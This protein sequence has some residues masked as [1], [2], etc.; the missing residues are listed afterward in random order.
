MR[1]L[2]T[3]RIIWLG[4]LLCVAAVPLWAHENDAHAAATTWTWEPSVVIPIFVSAA[5]YAI[6]YARMRRRAGAR[7]LTWPFVS[8]FAGIL[9]LIIALDSPVHLV[10]EQLFWVHMTQHELLMLIAAPLLVMG[11]PL[12]PFLWALPQSRREGLGKLS[13]TKAWRGTWIA[14]SS[15]GAAWIIHALALWIWH[16]PSLFEAALHNE[17]VHAVQHLCF[18]GSALLFWW[19][20]IHGRHGRLGYGAAVVYVFTTA[21]HNSILGALLTFAPRAWYPTYVSTAQNWSLTPLQD[22]QLGGLIMWVPAGVVLLVVGLA[23]FAA[24]L[25]ESQRRFEYTRMAALMKSAKGA[26]HAR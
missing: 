20:L 22:Q 13:K 18:L 11:R 25:G 8:C 7:L 14:I 16:A 1:R 12:V 19:T 4:A 23:L 26:A 9:A 15:A 3:T 5:L 17:A 6:G 2:R 24:W 21:A 10:G